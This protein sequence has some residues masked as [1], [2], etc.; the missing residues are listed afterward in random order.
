MWGPSGREQG[1]SSTG[2]RMANPWQILRHH[3]Q[4]MSITR[5]HTMFPGIGH[6]DIRRP[7]YLLTDHMCRAAPRRL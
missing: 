3:H 2:H 6:I 5:I 4:A 7:S 1:A